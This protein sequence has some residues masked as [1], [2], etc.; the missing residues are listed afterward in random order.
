MEKMTLIQKFSFLCFVVLVVFALAFGGIITNILKRNMLTRSKQ[1]TAI[2]V[3]KEVKKT[4]L[5][6]DFMLPEK[7]SD[8]NNLSERIRQLSLLPSIERIKIWNKDQI[9]VWSDKEQLVGQHFPDN[10]A[11]KRALRGEIVSNI[12]ALGK[13]EHKFEHQFE[14][15]MELYIPIQFKPQG[16]IAVVFEVYQNLD[17]LYVD[18]SHQKKIVWISAISGFA[19]LYFLL[20]GIVW[21]ASKRI[22]KQTKEIVQSEEKYRNLVQFALDGIISMA[23][24]GNIIILNKA[25]EQMFGYTIKEIIGCSLTMLIPEQ[26]RAKHL[27][28]V[29]NFLETKESTIIGKTIEIEGLHK[30][31]H[32]FPIELSLSVFG[33]GDSLVITGIIRD[34][35]ERKAVQKQ[36]IEM[37]RQ[38]TV[39]IVAGSI[40]HELNNAITGLLGYAELLMRNPDNV[41]LA[42]KSAEIFSSQA[43]HLKLHASNLLR[44]SKPQQPEMISISLNSL[45]DKVTDLLLISGLLKL[46]TIIKEYSE[47]L[48]QIMGDEMLLEQV[49]RNLEINAAH[50]MGSQGILTLKTNLS[51]N[52]SYVEF[53]ITDT[54]DGIPDEKR[55]NIFL[56]F[57]TTKEEG[58]GTGLGMY[59][60]KEVVG[61]HKGT[62]QLESKVGSGTKVSIGLPVVKG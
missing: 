41:E 1:L 51:E 59:I 9:V 58:K 17:P 26:Y 42:K 50:A 34:I 8:Y 4:F 15:L 56:P 19:I 39:S 35:S 37:E 36:L 10:E 13:V 48:P 16:N 52:K 27:A 7:V 23:S 14:M 32:I 28:G 57:D 61:Q 44:L 54:G 22:E 38:S 55:Q 29:N 47:D 62:I 21:R 12:S 45:L 3:S 6:S 40:G 2:F 46:Y 60:V 30:D 31:G 24:N 5:V 11:L 49:I 53:S 18:I 20:F 33:D 25:A 43:Q